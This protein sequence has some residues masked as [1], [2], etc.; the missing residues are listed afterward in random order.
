MLILMRGAGDLA[1]GTALRLYRSGFTVLMTELPAP[2]AVRRTVAFSEAMYTG[3]TT[4]E[5]ITVRR[6]ETEAETHAV[7]VEKRI[8]LIADP[9]GNAIGAFRPDVVVDARIA[10]RNIDT[11]IGDAPLVV[12]LGP[13]FTAGVDCHVVVETMRGHT[14]GRCIYKGSAL[15]N[16]GIPGNVGGFTRERVLYAPAAG[17]FHP[18]R[19]IGDMVTAGDMLADVD[20]VPLYAAISGCLRGILPEGIRVSKGMKAGDIDA[21]CAIS[22]CFTVS[23]KALSIG[24]GVLEAIMHFT[25]FGNP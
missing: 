15:P 10:K 22:H 17:V 1:T 24:G 11:H 14:L 21:R 23:D 2:A 18:H 4:V 3:H 19:N 7:L 20:G 13:G 8:A 12:A 16:T 6:C 5:G 25:A 9:E